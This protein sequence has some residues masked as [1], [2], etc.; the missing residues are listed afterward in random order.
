MRICALIVLLAACATAH[1]QEIPMVTGEH[2]TQS[3]NDAKKAYLVGLAN[4]VQVEIAYAG[5]NPASDGQTVMPRL[6]RGMR[7][8]TLDGVS[9]ALDAWYAK[10]P[11]R[12]QRPVL[13][14]I[15]FE[16]AVP[17]QTK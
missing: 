15:W 10:N 1:A 6:A 12:I 17:G 13:E 7:G 16:M 5:S 9:Q 14:V 4:M 8:Q 2:W 11:G 3:S